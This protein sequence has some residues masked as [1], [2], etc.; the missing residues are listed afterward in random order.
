[1]RARIAR[2]FA[3][4]W[5]SRLIT[6]S[7]NAILDRFWAGCDAGVFRAAARREVSSPSRLRQAWT[8]IWLALLPSPPLRRGGIFKS[9]ASPLP[10][11]G[12]PP[13]LLFERKVGSGHLD[14]ASLNIENTARSSASAGV[15]TFGWV[16]WARHL[17]LTSL[18]VPEARV[19]AID[20]LSRATVARPTRTPPPSRIP[21]S[22]PGSHEGDD[23][24]YAGGHE[25][26]GQT[27]FAEIVQ[28]IEIVEKNLHRR[29]RKARNQANLFTPLRLYP[30]SRPVR[31][32]AKRSRALN[33]S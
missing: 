2:L 17:R 5:G 12:N 29:R 24:D 4:I 10:R 14:R 23:T 28:V 27:I 3:P 26:C 13:W 16:G 30:A 11:C 6:R 1:M 9:K 15:F 19:L 31:R 8:G 22:R 18:T 7:R 21:G 32:A 25:G 33:A 20:S